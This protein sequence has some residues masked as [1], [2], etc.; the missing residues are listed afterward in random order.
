M[1]AVGVHVFWGSLKEFTTCVG[2]KGPLLLSRVNQIAAG[3]V[4][5][6]LLVSAVT[7]SL[8]PP[9]PLASTVNDKLELQE[10]LEHGR[11]AKVSPRAKALYCGVRGK[12]RGQD[13]LEQ[14][15]GLHPTCPL[16]PY[17]HSN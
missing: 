2:D 9:R 13:E 5:G 7:F 1:A 11:I 16:G 10:C 3:C 14:P 15:P 6:V 12:G 17:G 4:P 8:L